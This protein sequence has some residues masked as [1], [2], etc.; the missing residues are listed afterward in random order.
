[1]KRIINKPGEAPAEQ[2]DEE[3]EDD[4]DMEQE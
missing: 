3:W 4:Y 1:M 2:G